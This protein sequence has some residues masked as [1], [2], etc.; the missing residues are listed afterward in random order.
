MPYAALSVYFCAPLFASPQALGI[1]DWDPH[2]FY[3]GSILKTLVE[4]GRPP[5]WNPWYCGGGVLWQNPQAALFSPVYPLAL[6]TSLAVAM[7]VNVVLHYFLG[8][9]G[10]HLLLTEL[11]LSFRPMVIF[12]AASFVLS[13]ALAMHIAVGH[14][15]FLAAFYLPLQLFFFLRAVKR[16]VFRDLAAGAALL[17]LMVYNGALHVVPL[18]LTMIGAIGTSAVLFGRRIAP[19]ALAIALGV[20]GFAYGAPKLVPVARFVTGQQFLD[21]RLPQSGPSYMTAEM[22]LRAYLDPYQTRGMRVGWTEY[23]NYIGLPAALL[24]ATGILWIFANPKLTEAWIGRSLAFTSVLLLALS[25]GE[26]ARFAPASLLHEVPFFSSFR[27]PSR[28]T[29]AFVL[30]AVATTAWVFGSVAADV[31]ANPRTRRFAAILAGL[32]TLHIAATNH[33]HFDHIFQ[34]APLESRFRF[35]SR[36]DAPV[37]DVNVNP[38]S[39]N[40][41]MLRAM[42]DGRSTFNC[43]EVM[44]LKRTAAADRPLISSEG[45]VKLFGTTFEPN[46]VEFSVAAGPGGSKIFL[47]QNFADGWKSNAGPVTSDRILGSPVVTL[48]SG[49]TGRFAFDFTP[50]GLGMG[51]GILA[52]ALA[53]TAV[54]WRRRLAMP[55]L[56]GRLPG[57]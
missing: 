4:Y 20:L 53:L 51:S 16:R 35:L 48:K 34:L 23:G 21:A 13:G 41:P 32:A 39:G 44:Q 55:R 9:V 57:P 6:V 40:S 37:N 26:F 1:L 27:L 36:G 28:N 52:F 2:F 38:Y 54:G 8:F 7:K 49:Q 42:M 25:A 11:E 3:Y 56:V 43:Y 19:L 29:I 18:A 31:L 14:A 50:P 30:A 10:M 17:A 24:I 22:L 47:N 33:S 46:R 5:F 45:D 12:L 15:N